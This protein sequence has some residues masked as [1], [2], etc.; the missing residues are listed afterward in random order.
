MTAIILQ[1]RLPGYKN[2]KSDVTKEQW[3]KLVAPFQDYVRYQAANL[4]AHGWDI[5]LLG[6][7]LFMGSSWGEQRLYKTTDSGRD[8]ECATK[9]NADDHY[10]L[11][12]PP[13]KYD[14]RYRALQIDKIVAWASEYRGQ[15]VVEIIS[16]SRMRI[17][18]VQVNFTFGRIPPRART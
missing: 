12:D 7:I 1:Q 3:S 9:P 4:A 2:F 11:L 10:S 14:R 8:G 6:D 17:G 18:G 15:H 13:D 5:V 16:Q